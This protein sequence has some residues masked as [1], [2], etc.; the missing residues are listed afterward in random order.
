MHKA[1]VAPGWVVF[2]VGRRAPNGPRRGLTAVMRPRYLR[3]SRIGLA[4]VVTGA[5][6]WLASAQQPLPVPPPGVTGTATPEG[7]TG[8]MTLSPNREASRKIDAVRLYLKKDAPPWETVNDVLQKLLDEKSDTFY[9]LNWKDAKG[10]DQTTL[11]SVWTEVNRLIAAFPPAGK[12]FYRTAFGGLARDALDEAVTSGDPEKLGRVSLRYLNTEAGL[13]ATRLLGLV[14]LRYGNYA[15]AGSWFRRWLGAAGEGDLEPRSLFAAALSMKRAGDTKRAGEVMARLSRQAGGAGVVWNGKPTPVNELRDLLEGPSEAVAFDSTDWPMFKGNVARNAS[16]DGGS[17]F[18]SPRYAVSSILPEGQEKPNWDALGT[19]EIRKYIDGLE[20][21]TARQVTRSLPAFYPVAAKDL[22]VFRTYDGVYAVPTAEAT[23]PG[24]GKIRWGQECQGGLRQLVNG[25]AQLEQFG[26]SMQA[27]AMTGDKPATVLFENGLLGSLSHDGQRVYFVDDTALPAHPSQT[28]SG[29]PFGAAPSAAPNSPWYA[30]N[31]L[32]ALNLDTGLLAWKLGPTTEPANVL[33]DNSPAERLTDAAYLG[34]PLPVEGRLYVIAEKDRRLTLLC[35]DPATVT[36]DPKSAAPYPELVWEQELGSPN[37]EIAKDAPR[38]MQGVHMAFAEGVLVVPTNAGYVFGIEPHTRSILWVHPY[39]DAGSGPSTPQPGG[40]VFRNG[41]LMPQ[42]PMNPSE[43]R[44]QASAPV[45]HK[46][47]VLFTAWD[48]T[49]LQCLDLR[50]GRL[51]WKVPRL[52]NDQYFAGVHGDAAL[53]VGENATRAISLAPGNKQLWQR[54]TGTPLGVGAIAGDRF[55]LPVRS[56]SAPKYSEVLTIDLK[57]GAKIVA[58]PRFDPDAIVGNVLF[59]NRHVYMQGVKGLAAYEERAVKLEETNKRLAAKP[60]DPVGLASRGEIFLDDRRLAESVRD[61]EAA[62]AGELPPATR[63]KAAEALFEAIGELLREDFAAG[64]PYL[65]RYRELCRLP[66]PAGTPEAKAQEIAAEQQRRL[67]RAVLLVARGRE[68]QG[69]AADAVDAYLAYGT[70]DGA[71]ELRADPDDPGLFV[72][73][74]AAARE[75]IR[76]L[77][78]DAGADVRRALDARLA[79]EWA[80]RAKD[81]AGVRTF[82]RVVGPTHPLGREAR[83][84]LSELLAASAAEDDQRESQQ[85][86]FALQSQAGDDPSAAA[87][88]TLALADQ[89]TR[90]GLYEDAVRQLLALGRDHPNVKLPDGRTGAEVLAEVAADRRFVPYLEPLRSAWPARVIVDPPVPVQGAGVRMG[91]NATLSVTVTPEGDGAPFFDRYRVVLDVQTPR[92]DGWGLRL[93]D[94]HT[95]AEYC[96]LD[97]IRPQGAPSAFQWAQRCARVHGHRLYV[98]LGTEVYAYDV[99][100]KTRLWQKSLL[101]NR[102]P[103]SGNEQ[104]SLSQDETGVYFTTNSGGKTRVGQLFVVEAD[105]VALQVRDTL[106][107]LDPLRGTERWRKADVAGRVLVFGDADTVIV[108]ETASDGT[109]N[110]P[111]AYRAADGAPVPVP[112]TSEML[113]D[114][115]AGTAQPLGLRVL[116]VD[117]TD[118]KRVLRLGNLLTGKYLW[119][120]P[121]A[122]GELVVR[123]ET[124]RQTGVLGPD[125]ALEVWDTLSRAP[126]FKARLDANKLAEHLAKVNEVLLLSDRDRHFVALNR[127][128]EPRQTAGNGFSAPYRTVRLN[129]PVYCFDRASGRRLWF[130]DD[131]LENQTLVTEQFADLPVLIAAAQT[132]RNFNPEAGGPRYVVLEKDT[133]RVRNHTRELGSGPILNVQTDLAGREPGITLIRGDAT[134][135]IRPAAR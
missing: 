103:I 112:D 28:M 119:E 71:T 54:K 24:A 8:A 101:G 106:V 5:V 61:L 75:R 130:T 105:Y 33:A 81:L 115:R 91:G 128:N 78:A 90:K 43:K 76:R 126:V 64:E 131:Q 55:Y 113:A 127:P 65:E 37:L 129:G 84:K 121:L 108:S 23:G 34:P 51:L 25:P 79:T 40:Q 122:K 26:K 57:D 48:S 86:L 135:R 50:D 58:S 60:T 124:P 123:A 74:D 98:S 68:R 27:Y 83:L 38:R 72:R 19:Q 53:I 22:I 1:L 66:V 3:P 47:T 49:S 32:Y 42:S 69:R 82:T 77:V 7:L 114:L 99:V 15:E 102:P 104:N 52:T 97:T 13:E 70:A 92:N 100:S 44:W 56:L 107:V 125:G 30:K 6:A 16:A 17:P 14:Q 20:P 9:E 46:G 117:E 35:V 73:A 29:Q 132:M 120:R 80:A 18:R 12:Q 96:R 45:I 63:E 118:G 31:Q 4:L 93:L 134:V 11:V 41:M 133:G 21:V 111:R 62:L 59:H 88:A 10:R 109:P 94:R 39:K 67:A 89:L 85:V 95:G 2:L 116:R 36:A 110:A 87:R